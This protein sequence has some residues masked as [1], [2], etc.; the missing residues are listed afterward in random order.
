[1]SHRPKWPLVVACEGGEAED[2]AEETRVVV[3]LSAEMVALEA[4]AQ[5][6]RLLAEVEQQTKVMLAELQHIK[7]HADMAVAVAGVRQNL[8]TTR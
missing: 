1:M 8:E 4:E 6:R 5:V 3:Q 2:A 7:Q